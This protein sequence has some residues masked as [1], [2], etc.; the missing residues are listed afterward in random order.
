MNEYKQK[1]IAT[2]RDH[3]D[4]LSSKTDDQLADLYREWSNITASANWLMHSEPGIKAFCRWATIA[5]C[6]R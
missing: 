6:D 1:T 2:I 5:P 4:K 3:S